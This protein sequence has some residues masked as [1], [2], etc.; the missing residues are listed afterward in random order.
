MNKKI[1]SPS[2]SAASSHSA[3]TASPAPSA[4]SVH[5]DDEDGEFVVVGG[6]V[7]RDRREWE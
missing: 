7:R 6:S 5:S 2:P 4:T 3:R 1:H